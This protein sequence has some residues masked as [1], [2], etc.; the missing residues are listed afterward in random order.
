LKTSLYLFNW[1][2]ALT[3][4]LQ[5]GI[6]HV[7]LA[8]RQLPFY[9]W[10]E[11]SKKAHDEGNRNAKKLKRQCGL[12]SLWNVWLD[13]ELRACGFLPEV[14]VRPEDVEDSQRL[15]HAFAV[16][17]GQLLCVESEFGNSAHIDSN[18]L[19]FADAFRWGRAAACIMICPTART[20][21]IT[22]GGSITF[23][24]AVGR[25]QRLHPETVPGPVAIVGVDHQDANQVNLRDS[26]IQDPDLLSG[27]GDKRVLWHVVSELRAGVDLATVGLPSD[28]E[29]RLAGIERR[30]IVA[31][32]QAALF[33]S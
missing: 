26:L 21:A 4:S 18:T 10:P 7:L 31:A 29:K 20:A 15:D 19:K 12:Q 27:N 3:P 24:Q 8:A 14:Q 33:D 11:K 25:L 9:Y 32:A 5:A 17:H 23:E 22:T 16:E 1:P 30:H 13:Q 2:E 6:D 28:V